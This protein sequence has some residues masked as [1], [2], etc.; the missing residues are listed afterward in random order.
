MCLVKTLLLLISLIFFQNQEEFKKDY[1]K[2]FGN[3]YIWA[4]NWLILHDT[5]F[6]KQSKLFEIPEKSLKAIVFPELIRYN[7]VY[8]AIEIESLKYLYVKEG[9]AYADFSVGYFQMKP[10]FAQMVENDLANLKDKKFIKTSE[11]K[12]LNKLPENLV[13]RKERINRITN[14]YMQLQ[15]LVAFY[16]ICEEKF[17]NEKFTTDNEKVKYFSTCYNSG[18]NHSYKQLHHFQELKYFKTDKLFSSKKYNYSEISS[19]YFLNE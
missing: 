2:E 7:N 3:S 1:R 15:Y 18:Y 5:A 16:K 9:Q 13:K 11:L 17:A 12:G 10:S 8:N 6:T 4:R 19:F 14:I